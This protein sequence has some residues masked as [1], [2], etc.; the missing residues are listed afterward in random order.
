MTQFLEYY[1]VFDSSANQQSANQQSAHQQINNPANQQSA[2]QQITKSTH[3]QTIQLSHQHM[4]FC[5]I[6]R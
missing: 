3:H 5:H 6:N 1:R 2:N 4:P